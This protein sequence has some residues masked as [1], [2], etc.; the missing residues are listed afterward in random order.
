MPLTVHSVEA[1]TR[2]TQHNAFPSLARH[3]NTWWCTFRSGEDHVS[4]DGTAE[5]WTRTDGETSWQQRHV[6]TSPVAALPDLR[7]PRVL[8]HDGGLVVVAN[9]TSRRMLREGCQT[10][11]WTSEDGELWSEPVPIGDRNTWLWSV[12]G[13]SDGTALATTYPFRTARRDLPDDVV[14]VWRWPLG[15]TTLERVVDLVDGPLPNETAVVPDGDGALALV[16]RFSVPKKDGGTALFGWAPAPEGPWSLADLG[17]FV[18]GPAVVRHNGTILLGGRALGD[19]PAR[20]VLWSCE[21]SGEGAAAEVTTRELLTLP[22]GGD[23]GYP[24][25]VSEGDSVHLAYYSSHEGSATVYVV[26]LVPTH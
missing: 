15:G 7:D 18:G 8:W 9:A 22:S 24:S 21:V 12:S 23:N 3:G 26:E 13:G 6:F 1:V 20:T 4:H 14:T 10:Y 25:F 11:C 17:F 2:N 5:L 19:Q 16:R